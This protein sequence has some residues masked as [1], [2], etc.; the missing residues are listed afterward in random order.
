MQINI[1]DS[2]RMFMKITDKSILNLPE[3]NVDESDDIR[4]DNITENSNP[5]SPLGKTLITKVG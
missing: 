5:F 4:A 2:D 1:E 3:L